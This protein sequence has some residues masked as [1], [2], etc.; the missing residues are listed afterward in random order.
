MFV[1]CF[2]DIRTKIKYQLQHMNQGILTRYIRKE[3]TKDE[4]KSVEEWLD[5]NSENRVVFKNFFFAQQAFSD[6]KLI[7][8]IDTEEALINLKTTIYRKKRRENSRYKRKAL[9]LT[10]AVLLIPL[11]ILIGFLIP[12]SAVQP[13]HLVEVSTNPGVVS[14]FE[15]PDSTKVWLNSGSKLIYPSDFD[16]KKRWVELSGEGF[17]D[18]KK[19]DK[20]FVVKIDADY[21]I[22]VLG[23]TFNVQAY[24]DDN[25]IKTTLLNGCVQLNFR[26]SD[27]LKQKSYL[28]E[29]ESSCYS[30]ELRD[31]K[32]MKT[33]VDAAIAWKYGRIVFDNHP[34]EE[35][36][37]ILARHYNVKFIVR[38]DQIYKSSITGKFD[39]EQLNQ[40]LSYVQEATGIN[41]KFKKPIVTPDGISQ[42]EVILF[43]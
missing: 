37:Q 16:Q 29:S 7:D 32:I 1:N 42:H 10:A 8:A 20:P 21:S 11:F 12:R 18:V 24:A 23:T 13:T 3:L 30:R 6:L 43:K 14:V 5:A 22:K 19:G 34:I 2:K 33:D 40:I 25:V 31:M 15:L 35:V 9:Q 26:S 38:N 39:N 28:K 41:Y 36:L 27:D 17:F 4:M